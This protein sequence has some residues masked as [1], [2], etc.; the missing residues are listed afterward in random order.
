MWRI[1]IH[2]NTTITNATAFASK[3][4]GLVLDTE[5][6]IWALIEEVKNSDLECDLWP[7]LSMNLSEAAGVEMR[8]IGPRF[9]SWHVHEHCPPQ[10]LHCAWIK[11][12]VFDSTHLSS[13]S[14]RGRS[15]PPFCK[16][17]KST[18]CG[19]KERISSHS[20]VKPPAVRGLEFKPK[21]NL[22]Y[23]SQG[24]V[25]WQEGWWFKRLLHDWS[26]PKERLL[27]YCHQ[28]RWCIA[29]FPPSIP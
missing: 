14:W 15:L 5:W 18:W 25:I 12:K 27:I 13:E 16:T 26:T 3:G 24:W 7:L 8:L 22:A 29:T 10:S 2:E 9:F 6:N 17:E 19:L 1:L 20:R 4:V 28:L 11:Q 23:G 21:C